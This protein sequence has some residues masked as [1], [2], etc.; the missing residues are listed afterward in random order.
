MRVLAVLVVINAFAL[1]C[2]AGRN[3]PDR[4]DVASGA[5]ERV[6]VARSGTSSDTVLASMGGDTARLVAF[7][8]E[9][10]VLWSRQEGTETREQWRSGDLG[11]ATPRVMFAS[12]NED[13]LPDLLFALEYE[14]TVGGAVLL[15]APVDTAT[16]AY[17]SFSGF[18]R[19][20]EFRDV[21]GDGRVEVIEFSPGAV[22]L[23]GCLLDGPD[24]GCARQFQTEWRVALSFDVRTRTY[25]LDSTSHR[26]FYQVEAARLDSVA[27]AMRSR[28]DACSANAI[29]RLDAM[30]VRARLLGG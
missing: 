11:Y 24:E 23:E 5:I 13:S 8:S 20:P 4:P 14:E 2:D 7:G 25:R 16:R 19:A 29:A 22:S 18:C 28:P 15:G 17:Q 21:D 10:R 30:L 9:R 12:V 27:T 3:R 26:A 1:A 6:A